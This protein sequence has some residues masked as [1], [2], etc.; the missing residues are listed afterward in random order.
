MI[1]KP[2][3]F[4]FYPDT[5]CQLIDFLGGI[6]YSP[7]QD[8][9][10]I[11]NRVVSF[12]QNIITIIEKDKKMEHFKMTIHQN[13]H[14]FFVKIVEND[15]GPPSKVLNC[16]SCDLESETSK[17]SKLD[18]PLATKER[19]H[20]LWID[21]KARPMFVITPIRHV[22][23]LSECTE[24]EIF[25]M[26]LL[27]I[28]TL[29]EEQRISGKNGMINF[30]SFISM[31]LNHGNSRNL[32]HLHLKIRL[33]RN[34]FK[35]YMNNGWDKAKKEKYAILESRFRPSI[36]SHFSIFIKLFSNNHNSFSTTS[37]TKMKSYVQIFGSGTVDVPPAILVHFDNQKHSQRYLFNCGEGTQRFCLQHKIK[38][39]KIKKI[40]FTRINWESFGGIP[41]ML[42]TLA[43]AGV[44][45]IKLY[46]ETHEFQEDGTE[47]KDENLFIKTIFLNPENITSPA[48]PS[49]SSSDR[50]D[51]PEKRA[52]E[53]ENEY[54]PTLKYKKEILS[55]MFNLSSR[56]DDPKLLITKKTKT[57]TREE[58]T[59]LDIPDEDINEKKSDDKKYLDQRRREL[60]PKRLPKSIPSS[61]SI[62]YICKGPDYKGKFDP[63]AAKALGLLPG[64]HYSELVKGNS[65]TTADGTIIHPHQVIGPSRA[66]V[67][68]TSYIN[69]IYESS[70]FVLYQSGNKD[71]QPRVIVH[72][73]GNGVLE[74]NRY[75]E[76]MKKFGPETER[77]MFHSTATSQFKLSKIDENQFRIP[78]YSNEPSKQLNLV[79][80]IPKNTKFAI[81]LLIYQTEPSFK[82]DESN[83]P[84]IF[85][86]NDHD[87]EIV[88]SLEKMD[89]YLN[90]ATEV[91]QEVANI[92]NISKDIPGKDIVVTTLGTGSTLP[93]KYRNVTATL[94]TIPNNGCILLDVGEGTYSSLTRHLGKH[95]D[96]MGIEKCLYDLKCIFIS[97][98]HADHHLG[99][100]RILSK[101]NELNYKNDNAFIHLIGP[102]RL[103]KWLDELSD[104]QDFGISKVKFIDCR[105]KNIASVEVIHC[106][107]SF[108]ISFEHLDGWKIVYSGDTRP[109]DN[110]VN[111]GEN[112]TL[113]I[114]EATFENDLIEEALN[115]KHST[116]DEA[117]QIGV[118]QRYPKV[119]T[120][121]DD[122]GRIAVSFDLM[123]TTI[124]DLYK[125]SKYL[126]AIKVLYSEDSEEAKD[127]DGSWFLVWKFILSQI[128]FV[129][130]LA[131]LPKNSTQLHKKSQS[132]NSSPNSPTQHYHIQQHL[133]QL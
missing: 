72:M 133:Q 48:A 130:E 66:D 6:H 45:D 4:I 77:I 13:Y 27:S 62:A 24:E 26:F 119:P 29:E 54:D 33:R 64:R 113:L 56:P 86:H 114:H 83:L 99:L 3:E 121:Q 112:A 87:S 52:R 70:E 7:E 111:V 60:F 30:I 16:M 23:R 126:K 58:D 78:Y 63:E 8:N 47:F 75:Q 89:E 98:M 84:N 95:G 1:A 11:F 9:G 28:Q 107:S 82:I 109:C 79:P 116:A 100:T 105:L 44:K 43:D 38:A 50:V 110:L 118:R 34:D 19:F 69:S 53:E 88:S 80:N 39:S 96:K 101:W 14:G 128:N 31:T 81:P 25:S 103:W 122:N 15:T 124:G 92:S 37:I 68:S 120:F 74:D 40:F 106:P 91:R 117:V 2:A 102:P 12:F 131:G 5:P 93:S 51:I 42:L 108:G 10:V 73:L 104:V 20:N 127:Y 32:A 71:L 22:E 115:K 125:S 21:A 90:I 41:G 123:Q 94:L 59:A 36:F 49:S 85:N 35:Y 61:T 76:W 132:I 67:P 46:V 18:Y 97:H 17:T 65:V 129:R 55:L 57:Q